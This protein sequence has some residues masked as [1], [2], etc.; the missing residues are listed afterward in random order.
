MGDE[1]PESGVQISDESPHLLSGPLE[2]VG[3]E[4]EEG[5]TDTERADQRLNCFAGRR[6]AM[7][8]RCS[9]GRR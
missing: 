8:R 2:V 6:L 5:D 3:R 1:G 4:E 7:G 9:A